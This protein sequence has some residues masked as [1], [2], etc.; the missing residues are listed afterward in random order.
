MTDPY[1]TPPMGWKPEPREGSSFLKREVPPSVF[2]CMEAL[3]DLPS[4]YVARPPMCFA[5]GPAALQAFYARLR[6]G[7]L[8]ADAF[9]RTA[10]HPTWNGIPVALLIGSA[11]H[12]EVRLVR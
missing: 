12:N 2:E 10:L 4:F 5:L 7:S 11:D 6:P 8:G 9:D 1:R 3:V